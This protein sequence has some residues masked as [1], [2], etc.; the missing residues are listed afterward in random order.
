MQNDQ[1]VQNAIYFIDA[2]DKLLEFAKCMRNTNAS[3]DDILKAIETLAYELMW[4]AVDIDTKRDKAAQAS[5]LEGSLKAVRKG[6]PNI[7]SKLSL[8]R[9]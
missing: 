6:F 7:K 5:W 3:K 8:G 4:K 9:R 1:Q 2:A